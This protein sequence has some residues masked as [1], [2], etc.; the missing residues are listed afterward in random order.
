MNRNRKLVLGATVEGGKSSELISKAS[1]GCDTRI[2]G[3]ECI[4]IE[5]Y[6]CVQNNGKRRRVNG[7]RKL[8]LGRAQ[9][10]EEYRESKSKASTGR[11][12]RKR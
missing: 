4:E 5:I 1:P 8:V 9:G 2:R 3:A 11:N 10:K 12:A 7:N 6:C